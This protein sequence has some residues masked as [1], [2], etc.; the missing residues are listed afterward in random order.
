[1]F[2][3][4]AVINE[5]AEKLGMDPMELRLK[6]ASAQGTPAPTARSSALRSA[7]TR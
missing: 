5:L 2:A 7:T 4:E 3:G 1:M 6:N